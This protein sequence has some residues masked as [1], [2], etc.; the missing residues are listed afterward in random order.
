MPCFVP[1]PGDSLRGS[2][3][4]REHRFPE[5]RIRGQIRSDDDILK[6]RLPNTGSAVISLLAILLQFVAQRTLGNP[7]LFNGFFARTG[8]LAQGGEDV[9]A[10]EV[11]HVRRSLPIAW[12]RARRVR[13]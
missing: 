2:G 5:R 7:K 4:A 1:Q 10:L 9:L 11:L 12:T 8:E 13:Y 6:P 3:L